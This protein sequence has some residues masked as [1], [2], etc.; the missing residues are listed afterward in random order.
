MEIIA[1]AFGPITWRKPRSV[2]R[3][4]G[5]LE[6]AHAP[7]R[8]GRPSISARTSPI[9][10]IA[11]WRQCR[12]LRLRQPLLRGEIEGCRRSATQR[13]GTGSWVSRRVDR[14]GDVGRVLGNGVDDGHRLLAA[15]HGGHRLTTIRVLL[16]IPF[17]EGFD[18][19]ASP[20]RSTIVVS[21]GSMSAVT[22]SSSPLGRAV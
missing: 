9:N 18:V 22:S 13:L 8:A 1:H 16:K 14:L 17:G 21:S 4:V 19:S 12:R 5:A 6:H 10:F 20:G 7:V 2:Y 15:G 11:V 3:A